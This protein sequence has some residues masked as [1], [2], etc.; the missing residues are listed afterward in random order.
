MQEKLTQNSGTEGAPGGDGLSLNDFG[1]NM[2]ASKVA[3]S[4]AHPRPKQIAIRRHVSGGVGFGWVL[5]AFAA[6]RG[7]GPAIGAAL[8]LHCCYVLFNLVEVCPHIAITTTI[9]V[10]ITIINHTATFA[11]GAP[12]PPLA[13]PAP[14]PPLANV[15]SSPCG[16]A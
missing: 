9:R 6:G 15:H 4:D 2:P 5:P 11:S 8:L 10:T 7:G 16:H 3:E 1:M 14:P 13:T 12:S